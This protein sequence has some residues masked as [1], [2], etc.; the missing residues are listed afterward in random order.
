M[1]FNKVWYV[2]SKKIP[3]LGDE[4][5]SLALRKSNQIIYN[6]IQKYV[7]T[8]S[9][10]LYQFE[11]ETLNSH[12]FNVINNCSIVSTFIF[13]NFSKLDNWML[14]HGI[15]NP[16][17]S[18]GSVKYLYSW[19]VWILVKIEWTN[20]RLDP[21][22][23]WLRFQSTNPFILCICPIDLKCLCNISPLVFG[24]VV[25]FCVCDLYERPISNGR[26][27]SFI[28]RPSF[29]FQSGH[30]SPFTINSFPHR[31]MQQKETFKWK[32]IKKRMFKSWWK[33]QKH[34]KP[35]NWKKEKNI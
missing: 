2:F 34:N 19:I 29:V 9:V 26:R 7:A 5:S 12:L 8:H 28:R 11:F 24:W 32:P 35:F 1:R 3:P 31:K 4:K 14:L 13:I 22:E 10:E 15:C 17:I 6:V 21:F 18:W 27:I 23:F 30:N 25:T 16:K 33:E 20:S